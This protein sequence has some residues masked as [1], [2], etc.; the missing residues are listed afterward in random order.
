MAASADAIKVH[1]VLARL[2]R[3]TT[4]ESLAFGLQWPASRVDEA[5]ADPRAA[6]QGTALRITVSNG[7]VGV[8]TAE[9][10]VS[11]D[12]MQRVYLKFFERESLATDA[13][14]MLKAIAEGLV[15]TDHERG[16]GAADRVSWLALH[17]YGLVDRDASG[18]LTLSPRV[19]FSLRLLGPKDA[20]LRRVGFAGRARK[21]RGRQPTAS[22]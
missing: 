4:R 16:F 7:Q 20:G 14:T 21:P 17:K 9:R 2:A 1:A 22:R 11:D 18:T 19:Q 5:I 12:E 10:L 15:Q 13:L 8:V 6:L 3:M